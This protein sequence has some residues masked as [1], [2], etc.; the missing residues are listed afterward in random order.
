MKNKPAPRPSELLLYDLEYLEEGLFPLVGVDEA[1]RGPL[2]GPVVAAAVILPLQG[3]YLYGQID[4]SKKLDPAKREEL[5]EY[6]KEVAVEWA[7]GVV[8]PPE[9][10]ALNIYQAT[11][12]AMEKA[13]AG[14]SQG[15]RLALIDGNASNPALEPSRQKCIVKG[16][17]TSLHIAAAS[18]L[19]KVT[20]DGMMVGFAKEYPGYSFASHKGYATGEHFQALQ[21]NGPTPIHRFSFSPVWE[22]FLDKYRDKNDL[23]RIF[24]GQLSLLNNGGTAWK[25]EENYAQARK[26]VQKAWS[27]TED[28]RTG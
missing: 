7:V 20:R 19:A 28:G 5:A 2:A 12:K 22:S 8:N 21:E 24:S 3:D 14:I 16:D 4:D 15:Y 17:G 27:L 11:L 18:I 25:R 10:D 26:I 9:I 1:G 6:I 23:G 13:L